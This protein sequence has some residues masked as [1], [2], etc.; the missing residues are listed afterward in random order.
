MLNIFEFN[1]YS[2]YLNSWITSQGRA[3]YGIKGRMG[4][5]LEVSSTFISLMLKWEKLLT[6]DQASEMCD[7]LGLSDLESEYLHLLAEHERAGK[8]RYKEKIK[9]KIFALKEQA[10]KIGRRVHRH[11]E[12]TD[13]QKAIYYSTWLY[14][15][16]RNLSAV[17]EYNHSNDIAKKLN[18]DPSLVNKVV[19]FLI[20]NELCEEKDGKISYGPASLH[21]DKDSPFV[22]KHHQNW[23]LQGIQKMENRRDRDLFFTSPMSV[24]KE[25][26]AQIQKM[27]PQFIQEV[28][29]IVG[30][31][32]SE[33]TTCLNIDW[34]EY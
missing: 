2:I 17:P 27:I 29:K 12:L 18:L 4:K 34:Y 11:K 28:M 7:F 26:A 15:G 1:S 31:S 14:T 13:E 22:N 6:P 25:T 23:R 21:V 3:G 20:E 33:I 30:P 16:I 32:P 5:A 8:I 9:K 10:N 24:S 19:K